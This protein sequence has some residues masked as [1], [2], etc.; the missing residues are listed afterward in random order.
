MKATLVISTEYKHNQPSVFIVANGRY[1]GCQIYAQSRNYPSDVAYWQ[2]A[3]SS[4]SDRYFT[5]TEVVYSDEQ[6]KLI[7]MLQN[8]IDAN[9]KLLK[10]YPAWQMPPKFNIRR[11][12]AYE[13]R[14]AFDKKQ[15]D[16]CDAVSNYNE[17]Y[18]KAITAA[19]NEL[20]KI[21]LNK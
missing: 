4:D 12:K 6:F 3:T 21:L 10:Q 14:V 5:V 8:S 17:P 1:Y 9:E 19:K 7:E 11:G 20:R 16:E 15:Q 2:N 13:E 18:G